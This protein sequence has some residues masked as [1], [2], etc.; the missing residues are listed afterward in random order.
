MVAGYVT[1]PANYRE[2]K[3][4]AAIQVGSRQAQVEAHVPR[5]WL[6]GLTRHTPVKWLDYSGHT[7]SSN[8]EP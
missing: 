4:K 5:Y 8:L 3:I 1:P 6:S 2:L 7:I